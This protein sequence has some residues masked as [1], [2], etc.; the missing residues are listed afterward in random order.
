MR[1]IL[2]SGP[3][4][5]H[6]PTFEGNELEYLKQC[7]DSTF[8][9]SVG[10]FVER[11]EF[12]LVDFTGARNAIAVVNGTAALQLALRTTGLQIGD[13]VLTPTLTFAA[14]AA[15]VV[16]AGGIPHFVD[17]DE[18]CFAFDFDRVADQLKSI[19][20]FRSGYCW[21][22]QTGRRIHSAIVVHIF[23]RPANLESAQK[24]CRDFRLELIEDA[25]ES[26]GSYFGG[27]HTGRF[28]RFGIF[29]FNGNKTITTG[30]GGALL[31]DDD[32]LAR[33]ARHLS[34]T[35]KKPHPWLYEH[36][37]VG[38]NFRMPNLNAALGCA[39]LE[40]LP[41]LLERKRLLYH[42]Y[43][44]AL[45]SI[46]GIRLIAEPAH[47]R[48]NFWLQAIQLNRGD[49]AVRDQ[50]LQQTNQNGLTTR[51]VW[52]LLHEQAPYSRFPCLP[53]STALKLQD[54]LINLPSGAGLVAQ[55]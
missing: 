48:S 41:V 23:G 11:F 25:A 1:R 34:T 45:D 10:K 6:E 32:D 15:A 13:E 31:T 28:G 22:K 3:A 29:S 17:C 5:L 33:T 9:S 50:I 36:D 55:E 52:N 7:I 27:V 18:E 49:R 39:Q 35:A 4:P 44:A 46:Q 26:L 37:S 42:R 20:E 40:Q 14:T 2:P 43:A 16:H 54:S 47:G 30:G 12:E 21:N 24:F 53:V 8:V 51:P 19:V 38:Y